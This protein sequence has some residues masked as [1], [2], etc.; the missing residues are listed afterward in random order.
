MKSMPN[1]DKD[2]IAVVAERQKI[3]Y[4]RFGPWT[5]PVVAPE[6]MPPCFDNWYEELKSSYLI[7]KLP[8]AVERRMAKP[9]SDLYEGL[10]AVGSGGVVYLSLSRGE[11]LRRDVAFR[12]V[13]AVRLAQELLSGMLRLDLAGGR[14]LSIPFNTV[15]A[16]VLG[17]FAEKVRT[18]CGG[19]A[20]GGIACGD[21]ARAQPAG[22]RLFGRLGS[23]LEPA[24]DDTLF[25]IQLRALRRQEPGFCVLAYQAPAVLE[26]QKE[27]GRRGLLGVAA[28]LLRWRLDG[29]LLAAA[30]SE[31]VLL[32]RGT[33]K[34][35][36]ARYRGYRYE[37][38][39]LS[40]AAFRGAV[41][42]PRTLPNGAPI[43][44]LRISATGHDY[45]LLFEA[46]PSAALTA[47]CP[48]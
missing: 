44:A 6:D 9:G 12:D 30:P 19:T 16:D 25:Q 34:A 23:P 38:T 13:A 15:S 4:D 40:A 5:Y 21:T 17:G 31:L 41:I 37:A 29:C 46:D 28:R 35:R 26:P 45:E 8:K 33:G 22:S 18:A 1:R 36:S 14:S 42:E 11:V 47:L 27:G 7:L 2:V 39:Y 48:N 3:E 43:F 24:E 10:L 32:V 20:C